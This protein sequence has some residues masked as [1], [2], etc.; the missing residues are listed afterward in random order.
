MSYRRL[1]ALLL[2]AL[3]TTGGSCADVPPAAPAAPAA[4]AD[5][6]Q[7]QDRDLIA[8]R[9]KGKV[10]APITV[11][12]MSDFQCPYCRQFT[13]ETFPAIEREF[14]QTGKVRWLFVNFPLSEIHPNAVAAAELAMCSAKQGKFWPMHDLLFAHQRTWGPL[15]EPGQFLLTLADSLRIPRDSIVPCVRGGE[16]RA[17]IQ[18]DANTAARIGAGST[19]TFLVDGMLMSGAYPVEVFKKVLDSIYAVK[20]AG[21]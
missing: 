9:S 4:A 15:R 14:V 19:P 12:E 21:R 17:L 1:S 13:L 3:A 6:A 10:D 5:T 11:V 8:A 20:T 2:V 18:K 16:L 7:G